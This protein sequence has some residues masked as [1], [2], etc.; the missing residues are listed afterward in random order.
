[1][2]TQILAL[3]TTTPSIAVDRL[4]R[5]IFRFCGLRGRA[6]LDV[7]GLRARVQHNEDVVVLQADAGNAVEPTRLPGD[8]RAVLLEDRSR[9]VD[10]QL[11]DVRAEILCC[12]A[13]VPT[14]TPAQAILAT[15]S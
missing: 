2:S 3:I 9:A 12:G 4:P 5:S 8:A 13:R 14:G 10:V 7:G 1:M 11:A 15:C 6:V